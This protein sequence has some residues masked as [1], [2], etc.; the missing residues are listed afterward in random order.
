MIRCIIYHAQTYCSLKLNKGYDD[1]WL[2]QLLYTIYDHSGV[3]VDFGSANNV[4]NSNYFIM[5][6]CDENN[7]DSVF[8]EN[9]NDKSGRKSSR[10]PYDRITQT[11]RRSR[12]SP[13]CAR[14]RV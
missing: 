4:T 10:S 13:L 8:T 12:L 6:L 11:R 2:Q 7:N 14:V 5:L 1:E 9:D 3:R